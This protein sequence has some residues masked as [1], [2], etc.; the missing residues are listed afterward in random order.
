MVAAG[1]G[2]T[3]LMRRLLRH[4]A[5]VDRP[6]VVGE[7]ALHKA[8]DNTYGPA[9]MRILLDAGANVNAPRKDGRTPL[10]LAVADIY[11]PVDE[12]A[13]AKLLIARGADPNARDFDGK[14]ALA[15]AREGHNDE[16]VAVLRKAGAIGKN[17]NL[18]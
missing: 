5:L 6:D 8:C 14:T 15:L 11:S 3:S 2:D 9:P 16:A 13:T 7:T 12:A 10:M 4:G 1:S 17:H 18:R